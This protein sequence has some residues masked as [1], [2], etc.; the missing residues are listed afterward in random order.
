M[1]SGGTRKPSQPAPVSGP[2]R[3]SRRTDGGPGQKMRDLP[4]AAYGEG[5]EFSNIQAGAPMALANGALTPS[6][7]GAPSMPM[8]VVP[9]GAPSMNPGQPVTAGA[10]M[11]AGPGMEVLGLPSETPEDQDR[12]RLLSYLPALEYIANQPNALPSLRTLV[13]QIKAVNGV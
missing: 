11:G 8:D 10:A 1:P 2:G 12:R 9:F 13:R 4:N 7:G 3:L 5:A 6:S